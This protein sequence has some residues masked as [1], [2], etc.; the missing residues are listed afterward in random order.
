MIE[1]IINNIIN[2]NKDEDII[3]YVRDIINEYHLERWKKEWKFQSIKFI[4]F[5]ESDEN[6]MFETE[7]HG[8]I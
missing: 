5:M 6:N 4:E 7:K 8:K 3:E 1:N 2:L